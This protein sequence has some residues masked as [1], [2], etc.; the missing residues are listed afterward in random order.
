MPWCAMPPSAWDGVPQPW[1]GF[2]CLPSVSS[3]N[4]A[5][6]SGLRLAGV[7]VPMPCCTMPPSAQDV[8][9][10]PWEGLHCLPG[11]RSSNR[12]PVSWLRLAGGGSPHALLCHASK[13]PGRGP[14]ALG[15]P[16]L[17]TRGKKHDEAPVSGL[18]LAGFESPLPW[19][20]TSQ[21]A[22][23]GIPTALERTLWSKKL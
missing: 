23:D 12:A 6:V 3:S 1:E 14:A 20:A 17:S 10:P 4:R 11:V 2:P 16:P 22:R 9:P 19:C 5:P 18:W 15:R 8:V 13:R 7:G 21:T